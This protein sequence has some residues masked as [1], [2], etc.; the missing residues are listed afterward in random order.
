MIFKNNI[1][2]NLYNILFSIF[3]LRGKRINFE[4]VI[5][6]YTYFSIYNNKLTFKPKI[7]TQ[8]RDKPTDYKNN[9]ENWRE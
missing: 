1:L 9:G 7:K 4:N 2:H 8:S 5:R 3:N 6:G